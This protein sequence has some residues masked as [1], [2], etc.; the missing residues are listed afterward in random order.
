MGGGGSRRGYGLPSCSCT[1]G[2]CK[3]ATS[4]SCRR[5]GRQRRGAGPPAPAG[6]AARPCTPFVCT[7]LCSWASDAGLEV[8]SWIQGRPAYQ[9][10]VGLVT[11]Q[12]GWV[13]LCSSPR[14]HHPQEP[15]P[16]RGPGHPWVDHLPLTSPCCS[17]G[18][19]SPLSLCPVATS[20]GD[21]DLQM[22]APVPHPLPNSIPFPQ[23]PAPS[24]TRYLYTCYLVPITW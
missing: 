12:S 9:A 1:T 17:R 11:P 2:G 18:T 4:L 20:G 10:R 23:H 14:V 7:R 19:S 13:A 15:A 6:P 8:A 16:P 21:L 24:D 3:A 22:P 5:R